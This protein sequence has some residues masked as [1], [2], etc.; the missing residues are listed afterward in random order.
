MARQFVYRQTIFLI[1]SNTMLLIIR[2][3]VVDAAVK[4]NLLT[5][6]LTNHKKAN[7]YA[8]IGSIINNI[9]NKNYSV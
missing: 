8:Y 1:A 7:V 5:R 3:V 9:P 4:Q 2:I 6:L